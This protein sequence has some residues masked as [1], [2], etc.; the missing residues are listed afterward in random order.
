MADHVKTQL[1]AAA[2][3]LLSGLSLTGSR[4]FKG[5]I[6]PVEDE[7]LP[8][9]L[10]ATPAE[11]PEY[12]SMGYPRRIRSRITLSVNAVTKNN[13]D[14]DDVL[15]AIEKEVRA[16]IGNDPTIGGLAKDAVITGVTTGL[17]GDGEKPR[18]MTAM[19]FTVEIHTKEDA[20]DIAR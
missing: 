13:D 16:A 11:D 18:G 10:I 14:L 4:V 15:D 6:Y 5:R 3:T 9:L 8:C 20:P 17:H 12:T 7:E 2:V 19:L 1:R